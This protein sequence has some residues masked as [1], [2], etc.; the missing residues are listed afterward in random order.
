MYIYIYVYT[1]TQ[2]YADIYTYMQKFMG[3]LQG[4]KG[5]S[6]CYLWVGMRCVS[7]QI[8]GFS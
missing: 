1:R 8:K 5:L 7:Q 2:M 6:V 4:F 3:S